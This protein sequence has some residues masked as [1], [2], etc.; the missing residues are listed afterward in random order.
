[1]VLLCSACLTFTK[2]DF[3]IFEQAQIVPQQRAERTGSRALPCFLTFTKKIFVI[4]VQ[5][6]TFPMKATFYWE[7]GAG[8]ALLSN[9]YK[10]DFFDNLFFLMVL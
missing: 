1:M 2:K 8:L 7:P 5:K 4:A 10:K 3:V 6:I 9:F